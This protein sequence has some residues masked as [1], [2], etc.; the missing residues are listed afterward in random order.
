MPLFPSVRQR[1]AEGQPP[2]KVS[3]LADMLGCS[4]GYLHKLIE[5][6]TLKVGRVGRVYR[7]PIPEAVKAAKAVGA[8]EE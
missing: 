8:I 5:A 1:F 2:L 7:I 6:G 4:R 3:E